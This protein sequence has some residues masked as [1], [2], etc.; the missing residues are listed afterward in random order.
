MRK[1]TT[2]DD[3]QA[4]LRT[5]SSWYTY[6]E[7]NPT[8][9]GKFT[10]L[11][12]RPPSGEGGDVV[13]RFWWKLKERVAEENGGHEGEEIEVEWPLAMLLFKRA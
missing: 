10:G 3:L 7:Q 1:K 11:S 12:R 6:C 9:S 4:Y 2:W 13:E 8:D 5:F